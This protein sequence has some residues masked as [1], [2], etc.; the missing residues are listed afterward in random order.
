MSSRV[1]VRFGDVF[2][3]AFIIADKENILPLRRA[4]A[5]EGFETHVVQGSYTSEELAMPRA[6]K[7]LLNHSSAWKYAARADEP[8]LIVEADFV[9]CKGISRFPMPYN[10]DQPGPKVSCVYA[11]GP[12]IYH[13]G[14]NDGFWGACMHQCCLHSESRGR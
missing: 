7:C 5:S 9:P 10:P 2:K 1:Q 14:K 12:V 8:A 11:A 6:I 3:K 4:L 13:Y